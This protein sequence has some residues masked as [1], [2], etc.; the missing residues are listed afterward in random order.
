MAGKVEYPE[1]SSCEGVK[2]LIARYK[3]VRR[4]A[5]A[6]GCSRKHV[7]CALRRYG[8]RQ[9]RMVVGEEMREKLKL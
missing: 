2:A 1:L 8:L 9:E 7:W 3:T 5:E 4:I 6:L